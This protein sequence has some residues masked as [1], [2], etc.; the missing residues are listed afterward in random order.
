M[1]SIANFVCF[2]Q[3][4]GHPVEGPEKFCRKGLVKGVY[5]DDV[6]QI[7]LIWDPEVVLRAPQSTLSSLPRPCSIPTMRNQPPNRVI[8]QAVLR[9]AAS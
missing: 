1:F 3:M 8:R 9:M 6:A 5:E 7:R 2:R 4:P